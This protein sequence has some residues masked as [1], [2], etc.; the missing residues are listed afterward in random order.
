MQEA[1]GEATCGGTDVDGGGACDIDVEVN[2]RLLQFE[3]SAGDEAEAAACKREVDVARHHGARLVD[4]G[5]SDADLTGQ[6]PG[7][8]P[9]AGDLEFTL[10]Q[11]E[12]DALLARLLGHE[13]AR[14][15]AAAAA[16]RSS[17]Q[18]T[19]RWQASEVSVRPPRRSRQAATS[20]ATSSMAGSMPWASA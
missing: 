4:D 12:V 8:G 2:E 20:E 1:V 17:T 9:F 3:A 13:R 18:S 5:G 6:D 15:A 10:D 14:R 19:M 16:A 11:E 7:A